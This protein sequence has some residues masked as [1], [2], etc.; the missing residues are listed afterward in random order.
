MEARARIDD[1]AQRTA[2]LWQ[3][4][5]ART[6]PAFKGG[7]LTVQELFRKVVAQ[8][9]KEAVEDMQAELMMEGVTEKNMESRVRVK[10]GMKSPSHLAK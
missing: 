3:K 10:L 6:D 2:C 5:R 8:A 1:A 4:W 7:S 9:V